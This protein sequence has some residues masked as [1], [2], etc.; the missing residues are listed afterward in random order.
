MTI[1]LEKA[2]QQENDHGEV[3]WT[4]W[5]R[6]VMGR[7]FIATAGWRYWP[8]KVSLSTPSMRKGKGDN[9][10]GKFFNTTSMSTGIYNVVLNECMRLF[11][12]ADGQPTVTDE[13]VAA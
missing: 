11:G 8:H 5:V 13:K 10:T 6:L 4:F 9:G 2:Q 3:Y 7:E 12:P 1:L